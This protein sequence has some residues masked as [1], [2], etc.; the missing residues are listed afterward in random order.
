MRPQNGSAGILS[1]IVYNNSPTKNPIEETMSTPLR[2]VFYF[3][4]KPEK[5]WEGL[6]SPESNRII[7]AGTDFEADVKPGGSMK[8]IG[9]GA[10]GE[11]YLGEGRDSAV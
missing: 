9:P 7:F 6:V 3:A 4:V 2:F 1:T 5:L 8:W 10:D 11:R